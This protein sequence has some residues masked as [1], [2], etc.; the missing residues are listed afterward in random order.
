MLFGRILP[1]RQTKKVG[2]TPVTPHLCANSVTKTME[3][4]ESSILRSDTLAFR[5]NSD[6]LI[7]NHLCVKLMTDV[8]VAPFVS[9]RLKGQYV[10][11]Y[12]EAGLLF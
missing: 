6:S 3:T 11:F 4:M 12:Y 9:L 10:I 8:I 2:D 5:M 1:S 7:Q